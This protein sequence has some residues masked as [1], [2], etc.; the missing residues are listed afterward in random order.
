MKGEISRIISR[1]NGLWFLRL[2]VIG[3]IIVFCALLTMGEVGFNV[4]AIPVVC[5]SHLLIGGIIII[6]FVVLAVLFARKS[7]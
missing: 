1:I 4:V 7:T 3:L 6:I 5:I 2:A